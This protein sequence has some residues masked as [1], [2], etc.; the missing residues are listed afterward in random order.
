MACSGTALLTLLIYHVTFQVFIPEV[1]YYIS[2]YKVANN[3]AGRSPFLH[4][5]RDV[6]LIVLREFFYD[7]R[8][9]P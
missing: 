6:Q 3:K 4:H 5:I 7:C 2:L 9:L 8:Q 1:P